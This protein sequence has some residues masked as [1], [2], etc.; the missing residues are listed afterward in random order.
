MDRVEL[1][2]ALTHTA[3]DAAGGAELVGD[4]A[5]LLVG[6]HN[7]RLAGAAGVDHDDLLGAD[8]GAGTTAG[9]QMCIRDS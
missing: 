4:S 7:D 5:L 2:G 6:A 8:V 1:T 3:G 9:T